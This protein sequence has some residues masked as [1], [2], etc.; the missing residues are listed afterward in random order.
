MTVIIPLALIAIIFAWY[1]RPKKGII[2]AR[3]IAILATAVP[4]VIISIASVLVQVCQ[5]STDNIV[6]NT[7]FIIGLCLAGATVLVLLGFIAARKTEIAKGI[8]FGLAIMIILSIV[9]FVS[10]EALLKV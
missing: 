9:E 6:A 10:L 5:N 4:L 3:W 8:G 2:K 7:L 1:Y